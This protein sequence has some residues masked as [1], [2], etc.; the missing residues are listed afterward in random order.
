VFSGEM[1]LGEKK[2]LDVVPPV[3]VRAE[4]GGAVEVIVKRK[5]KGVLGELDEPGRRVFH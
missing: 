2:R 1:V 4:N 3:R 5:D